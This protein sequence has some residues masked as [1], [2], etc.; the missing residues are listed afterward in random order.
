MYDDILG[1]HNEEVVVLIAS[2]G[3][4]FNILQA[5]NRLS[6]QQKIT[7]MPLVPRLRKSPSGLLLYMVNLICPKLVFSW[8]CFYPVCCETVK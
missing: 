6:Q 7:K 8:E 2:P 1:G 4:L 3:S 5:Q